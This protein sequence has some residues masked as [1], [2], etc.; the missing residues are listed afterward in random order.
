MGHYL[1]FTSR[2]FTSEWLTGPKCVP[3]CYGAIETPQHKI[4]DIRL[5]SRSQ[6]AVRIHPVFLVTAT[7]AD[8]Q[9]KPRE[10]HR[11][12]VFLLLK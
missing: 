5:E 9:G 12:L 11:S 4:S 8:I 3:D 7:E 1:P 2:L 10:K 6:S